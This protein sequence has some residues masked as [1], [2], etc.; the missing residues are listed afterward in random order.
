M[1]T[2]GGEGGWSFLLFVTH[3]WTHRYPSLSNSRHLSLNQGLATFFCKRPEGKSLRLCG[4]Y[5][6]YL[7][8]STQLLHHRAFE[9]DG[10]TSRT[11]FQFNFISEN[12]RWARSGL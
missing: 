4:S 11:E 6:P 7:S 9:G 1:V 8:K 10:C 5:G 2:L 3:A 12:R